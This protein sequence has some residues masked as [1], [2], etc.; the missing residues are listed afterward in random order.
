[1]TNIPRL[2]I[3]TLALVAL[4]TSAYAV[5]SADKK[6]ISRVINETLAPI[7]CARVAEGITDWEV[8][9][10]ESTSRSNQLLNTLS[11]PDIGLFEKTDAA[12]I[13]AKKISYLI[14][15]K[16]VDEAEFS[17]TAKGSV[18]FWKITNKGA[19]LLDPTCGIRYARAKVLDASIVP[20]TS[21]GNTR[22]TFMQL[23]WAYEDG[24]IARAVLKTMGVAPEQSQVRVL[25]LEDKGS[26]WQLIQKK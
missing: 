20:I 1:M 8:I 3:S 9:A 22:Q 14:N 7:G 24:D 4:S 15:S 26:G 25:S 21:S 5:S 13:S 18:Q 11:A 12:T 10:T 16:T 17:K 6:E 19:S 23:R 2:A